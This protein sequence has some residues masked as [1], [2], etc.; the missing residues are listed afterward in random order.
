MLH[1]LDFLGQLFVKQVFLHIYFF[2]FFF[3]KIYFCVYV[4]FICV[5]ATSVQR[6]W[7][8]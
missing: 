2:F 1:E 7:R 3:A 8:C 4:C 5:R 6:L